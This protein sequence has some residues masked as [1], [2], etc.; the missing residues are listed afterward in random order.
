VKPS[1]SYRRRPCCCRHRWSCASRATFPCGRRWRQT[2]RPRGA[3][4]R[5][6]RGKSTHNVES[7]AVGRGQPTGSTRVRSRASAAYLMRPHGDVATP[8]SAARS[9]RSA[10]RDGPERDAVRSDDRGPEGWPHD[11]VATSGTAR[12]G[13]GGPSGLVS[14]SYT[15]MWPPL[16]SLRPC[17]GRS[18]G[19]ART[20]N[21][22]GGGE[23]S[24][25]LALLSSYDIARQP[26]S[27]ADAR[28][29]RR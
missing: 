26:R 28:S 12:T 9:A 19:E 15:T 13:S 10:L 11:D 21:F 29:F 5:V 27:R 14:D 2:T 3:R 22:R 6:V 7:P 4:L 25:A 8:R 18:G 16:S 1:S 20:S 23:H 24:R 17:E